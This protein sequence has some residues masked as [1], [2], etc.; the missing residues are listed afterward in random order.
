M[1]RAIDHTDDPVQVTVDGVPRSGRR[2]ETVAALLLRHGLIPS[3]HTA[4]GA[5]RAPYCLMGA[6]FECVVAIDELQNVQ[7]CLTVLRDGM[8]IRR[9]ICR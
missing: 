3:R 4:S 9:P 8:A 6:C 7:A 5:A 2:G 1:F